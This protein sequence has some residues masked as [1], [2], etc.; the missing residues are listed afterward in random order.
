M[1][2]WK[3]CQKIWQCTHCIVTKV[4]GL[5]EEKTK[6]ETKNPPCMSSLSG[7]VAQYCV[8]KNSIYTAVIE[9]KNHMELH[10]ITKR[11][12]PLLCITILNVIIIQI[13]RTLD[14]NSAS[15]H[16]WRERKTN[17]HILGWTSR[18]TSDLY[19]TIQ[20]FLANSVITNINFLPYTISEKS[21]NMKFQSNAWREK[22]KNIEGRGVSLFPTIQK[23]IVNPY[24]KYKASTLNSC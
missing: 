13:P 8:R 16:D 24:T 6:H 14:E 19:P 17:K 3:N 21:I 10:V 5:Y 12:K 2:K 23:V 4:Y 15:I 9:R 22:K 20:K 11:R 18:E 1:I 7:T